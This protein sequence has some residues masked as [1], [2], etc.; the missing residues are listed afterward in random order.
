M[1]K[2][3]ILFILTFLASGSIFAQSWSR[4]IYLNSFE[5]HTE[6]SI[7]FTDSN[8][9]LFYY[10]KVLETNLYSFNNNGD[11]N[12]TKHFLNIRILQVQVFSN[13]NIGFIGD[14]YAHQSLIFGILNPDGSQKWAAEFNQSDLDGCS[15]IEIDTSNILFA[16][17]VPTGVFNLHTDQD[18]NIITATSRQEIT[19]YNMCSNSKSIQLN[20]GNIISA[21]KS[22]VSNC[23]IKTDRQDSILWGKVYTS[24]T[25]YYPLYIT[26]L[27]NRNILVSGYCGENGGT[28][29]YLMLT[30]SAGE[31]LWIQSYASTDQD[32]LTLF[33]ECYEKEDGNILVKGYSILGEIF[34]ITVDLTGNIQSTY[35]TNGPSP[36]INGIKTQN[37]DLK[38]NMIADYAIILPY[39]V[40]DVFILMHV[41]PYSS[42]LPC[43]QL[44]A[45]YTPSVHI[46]A[47][48]VNNAQF[49]QLSQPI[50]QPY[51]ILYGNTYWNTSKDC[52][53]YVATENIPDE[54]IKIYPNPADA[55]FQVD[56]N[57][58][59]HISVYD[60]QGQ[61]VLQTQNRYIATDLIPVGTYVI[62]IL[63]DQGN[64]TSRKLVISR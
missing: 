40:L 50:A 63:S 16:L 24:L 39:P 29:P 30:D 61:L 17:N 15:I 5:D 42:S 9:V 60:M 41:R 45:Q 56:G 6:G 54:E 23:L 52:G 53:L 48:T 8:N 11:T 58:I 31:L 14:H 33:S 34:F 20:D 44:T 49:T 10:N 59:Q 4:S 2:K 13:G 25:D 12:W 38:N 21:A 7:S 47:V 57:F 18:G 37:F 46:K 62:K 27:S 43:Y 26:E 35:K 36:Q 22:D 32:E 1:S 3:V 55:F 28:V 19:S 51:N 64:L